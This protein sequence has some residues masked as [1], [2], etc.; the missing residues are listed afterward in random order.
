[1]HDVKQTLPVVQGGDHIDIVQAALFSSPHWPL[2]QRHILLENMRLARLT[3]PI[4]QAQQTAYDEMIRAVG[5][6][7]HVDNLLIFQEPPEGQDVPVSMKEFIL[8]GIPKENIFDLTPEAP[9]EPVD[10][11]RPAYAVLTNIW[12]S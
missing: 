9:I 7:R 4:E 12:T 6:N 2:F 5:E 11:P 1:M 8:C 10:L 3:D